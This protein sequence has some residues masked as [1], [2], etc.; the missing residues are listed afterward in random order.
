MF[1]DLF[2][3][4]NAKVNATLDALNHD[5]IKDTKIY[6]KLQAVGGCSALIHLMQN[7][8]DKAIDEF[9]ASDQVTE[10]NELAELT[11]LSK[12]LIVIISWT[13]LSDKRLAGIT[14]IDGVG[15]VVKVMQSF[16]EYHACNRVCVVPR[17]TW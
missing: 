15:S 14:A 12:T 3:S 5:S 13:S 17:V 8:L 11:T 2:H 9:P 4:A 16:P 6:D 1:Q 10:L 7:G